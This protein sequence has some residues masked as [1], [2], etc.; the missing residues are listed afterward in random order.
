MNNQAMIESGVFIVTGDTI[1][2]QRASYIEDGWLI[3]MFDEYIKL[4]EIPMGGGGQILIGQY[5]N[6]FDALRA[7]SQLN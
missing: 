1:C 5:D 6:L 3:E 7:A 4:F 2:F